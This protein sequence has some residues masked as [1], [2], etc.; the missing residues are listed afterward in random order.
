MQDVCR[1]H[2]AK[3]E[4]NYPVK[5][6][7]AKK[8]V[9][10]RTVFLLRCNDR[11]AVCKR[12]DKGLL[13]GLWQFPNCAGMLSAEQAIQWVS[14]TGTVPF[15]LVKSVER[16]HIFTHI[17]WEMTGYRIECREESKRFVW[18]NRED[19][20]R[21]YTLPTAFRMFLEDL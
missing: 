21:V 1:A 13:A 3:A 6:P 17:R 11:Y 5:Q 15:E 14:D 16:V 9:E 19:L 20:E 10:E 7:K 8:R 4:T 2:A 18:A 12:E